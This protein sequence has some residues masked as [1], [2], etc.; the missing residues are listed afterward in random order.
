MASL[1]YFAEET[2]WLGTEWRPVRKPVT[3]EVVGT[4]F[5]E[6]RS[7]EMESD[8]G[9]FYDPQD[10]YLIACLTIAEPSVDW[11]GLVYWRRADMTFVSVIDPATDQ[12]VAKI[13]VRRGKTSGE[14][15]WTNVVQLVK[16]E[17]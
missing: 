3:F 4:I 12:V 17:K 7:F 11:E 2:C 5:G 15:D 1:A 10:E 16:R 9:I 13:S 14:I 6:S 8:Y